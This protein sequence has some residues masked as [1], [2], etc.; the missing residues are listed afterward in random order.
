MLP[1]LQ[2]RVAFAFPESIDASLCHT[3]TA[4]LDSSKTTCELDDRFDRF[5]LRSESHLLLRTVIP[6]PLLYRPVRLCVTGKSTPRW[7]RF[8]EHSCPYVFFSF[9][10]KSPRLRSIVPVSHG[11]I[12]IG[13]KTSRSQVFFPSATL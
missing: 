5:R 1:S 6:Y 8:P 9:F 13:C 11:R 4:S 3:V 7:P 12:Q 10:G 2:P